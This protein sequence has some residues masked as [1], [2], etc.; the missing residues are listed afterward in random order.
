MRGLKDRQ[1]LVTG[2]AS[3]IGAATVRRFL[4]EG[5]RVS[6]LDK[7]IDKGEKISE[8]MPKLSAVIQC[9]VADL[10]H[11]Q[12]AFNEA[13]Q[14]MGGVD[15]LIN[16]AGISIRHSFLDITLPSSY[17]GRRFVQRRNSRSS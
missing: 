6:V 7:D 16:N 10:S 8:E 17:G 2:G 13:I 9:D 14:A 1:V 4:E 3:G 5:S 15:V 12:E 11:V